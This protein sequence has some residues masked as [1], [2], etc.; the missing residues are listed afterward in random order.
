MI[1]KSLILLCS[2]T[3]MAVTATA[4]MDQQE[5]DNLISAAE[6]SYQL[7][8]EDFNVD[9]ELD[10]ESLQMSEVEV[11][12]ESEARRPPYK[13]PRRYNPPNYRPR[14]R[15]RPPKYKEVMCVAENDRGFRYRAYAFRPF[16]AE[17][18]ALRLC[19]NDFRRSRAC[20]IVG[21]K[22]TGG[23]FYP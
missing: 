20:R 7:D 8:L 13:Q 21:C 1:R 5:E 6:L 4:E 16:R 22:V 19:R 18:K 11:G 14:P 2:L 23:R 9:E 10:A 15:P 17:A 12:L 3:L